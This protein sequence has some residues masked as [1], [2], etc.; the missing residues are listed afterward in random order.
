MPSITITRP[1]DMHLHVRDGAALASVIGDS[2]RRFARAVIM[3]NLDPPVV[4]VDQALAYRRR[5]LDA[6]PDASSFSPM[7]TLYLTD[8][9]TPETIRA[10]A[11]CEH[12]IAVK[13]YP[14]GATTHSEHGVTR[15][16]NVY[17]AL[18]QMAESG[19]SLLMHGEVT[20]PDVDIFDRESV[21]IDV[22]LE[23]LRQ[24][25]PELKV[26]LEHITTLQAVQYVSEVPDNLAATITPQHLIHNRNALFSGGLRPHHYCL[27]V[28][29]RESH[30]QALLDAAVSGNPRYFLGTDSAPHSRSTKETG[31]GCAGI[32]TAHCA[33]ELYAEAFAA[34]GALDRLEGFAAFHGADFYGLPRNSG[35]VTLEQQ[36]WTV[37]DSLPF[38]GDEVVP[39]RAGGTCHWKLVSA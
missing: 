37:P 36:D 11:E 9:T 8:T 25:F 33:L 28:L 21:F 30:R 1:D 22:V 23:P 27:P 16:E 38:A 15:L 34:A 24:R 17:P 10:A 3:P 13:Y 4:D 7:M 19:L 2:A 35:T 31:C 6:L 26:V 5:I 12:V 18:E 39:L 29:K 20:T 14:A 32:Y